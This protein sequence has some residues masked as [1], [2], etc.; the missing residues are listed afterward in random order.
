MH[1]LMLTSTFPRF[2][3]DMQANFVGSQA[4]AWVKSSPDDEITILAP[5]DTGVPIF[6]QQGKVEVRRFVYAWPKSR[7]KLAYPAILPNLKKNP[8]LAAQI[9]GFIFSQY[10]EASKVC[11]EKNVDMVYAHW[12]MPQG[13][14]AWRL[15]KALG[16]P[17][18]LQTHSS[19]LS[20]FSKLGWAGKS[21]ARKLLRECDVFYCVNS[22]QL[23][24]ARE[25]LRKQERE[26]FTKKAIC[27]PM[28]VDEFSKPL[29]DY[30]SEFEI[31]TIARLSKKK[32]IDLLIRSAELLGER[33]IFPSIA[34]AGDGE[35]RIELE[36]LVRRS[37]VTFPGFLVGSEKNAF[38]SNAQRFAFPAKAA[39]DD[40]EG[41]PVALLEALLRGKPVLAS[42]DTN[43]EL[44]PEWPQLKERVV[45]IE[46]PADPVRL[47]CKLEE[48]LAFNVE[49]AHETAQIMS[50]YRWDELISEYVQ[51]IKNLGLS[52]VAR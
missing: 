43:I 18:A 1:I 8:S 41:L 21:L 11:R 12:V 15:K 52:T 13:I 34:I 38:L 20:V 48:L 2:S 23:E 7:Q 4:A 16:I 46:D 5:H 40:V 17:Y 31:A 35:D 10:R 42:R 44:L 9:P 3:G 47:A 27:L 51:P 14:V 50:R 24:Y 22:N 25:L 26:K 30:G 32:G 19:D 39:G 37:E 28:G 45:F 49:R 29:S 6:E 36:A 33:G